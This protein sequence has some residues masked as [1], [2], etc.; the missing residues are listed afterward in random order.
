[1]KASQTRQCIIIVLLNFIRRYL[2]SSV[3]YVFIFHFILLFYYFPGIADLLDAGLGERRHELR[4][5]RRF[6]CPAPA[7]AHCRDACTEPLWV[8]ASTSGHRQESSFVHRDDDDEL[9]IT[10]KIRSIGKTHARH[11]SIAR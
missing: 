9:V 8:H 1:M 11:V 4:Q 3:F 10:A 5:S 7:A 6:L 2:S